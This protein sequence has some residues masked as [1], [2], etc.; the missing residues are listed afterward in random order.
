MQLHALTVEHGQLAMVQQVCDFDAASLSLLYPPFYVFAAPGVK[1]TQRNYPPTASAIHF[2]HP[3]RFLSA[4]WRLLTPLFDADTV[5]K[6]RVESPDA[7]FERPI[8]SHA[9][10][11]TSELAYLRAER[12][13]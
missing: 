8:G 13:P 6:M 12:S 1:M 4:L 3:P 10:P 5:R 7:S 11:P 2:V 9:L